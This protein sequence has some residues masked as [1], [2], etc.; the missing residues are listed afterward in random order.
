MDMEKIKEA[1]GG[2]Y[3]PRLLAMLAQKNILTVRN[4]PFTG[5]ILTNVLNGTT[6]HFEAE[7]AIA[8][9]IAETKKENKKHADFIK[10]T[11]K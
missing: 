2:S 9:F 10:K 6:R 7:K 4:K 1:L 5:A 11:L 3:R 8:I